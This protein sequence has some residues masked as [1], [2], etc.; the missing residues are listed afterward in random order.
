MAS[1]ATRAAGARKVEKLPLKPSYPLAQ[2]MEWGY[3]PSEPGNEHDL[4]T[5]IELEGEH[6]REFWIGFQNFYVIS[7]Y[8]HSAVYSLAVYQLS[9]ALA[10][11]AR[12]ETG[13]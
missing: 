4:T 1:L 2:L 3:Q 10:A 13:P 11:G 12:E 9:E 6:G 8:N 5:L 7:R